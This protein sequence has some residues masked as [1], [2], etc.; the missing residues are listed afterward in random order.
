[1]DLLTVICDII[2]HE[3]SLTSGNVMVYNQSIQ[4]PTTKGLFVVVGYLGGKAIGNVNDV[5]DQSIGLKET[6]SISMSEMIQLDVMSIDS[7]AR[8]R[9]EEIIMAFHSDYAQKA[10]ETNRIQIARIPMQ[11]N[12]VSGVEGVAMLTRFVMTLNVLAVYTKNK[13]IEYYD[14]HSRSVPPT[15][16]ANL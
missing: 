6:Q 3:L 16:V 12:D 2:H 13:V 15:I 1:M 11:F 14:E 10:M 9:K 8:L 7:S 5:T 4:A